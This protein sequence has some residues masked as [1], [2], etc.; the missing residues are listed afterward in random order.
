MDNITDIDSYI[1]YKSKIWEDTPYNFNPLLKQFYELK[2][3]IKYPDKVYNPFYI[4]SYNNPSTI[5]VYAYLYK[6][7]LEKNFENAYNELKKNAERI[8]VKES[9]IK[10]EMFEFYETKMRTGDLEWIANYREE[11]LKL[12]APAMKKDFKIDLFL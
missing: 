3:A 6:A 9:P 7:Y 4:I 1:E 2:F 5:D 12:L 11:R 8:F 10:D